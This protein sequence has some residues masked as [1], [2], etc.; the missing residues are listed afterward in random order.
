MHV[1]RNVSTSVGLLVYDGTGPPFRGSAIPEDRV[2][3]MVNPS[4]PP[5]SFTISP[6]FCVFVVSS[7]SVRN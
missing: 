6:T 5:E 2:R 1:C 4:G 7:Y 3:V